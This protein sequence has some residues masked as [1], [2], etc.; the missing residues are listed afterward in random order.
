MMINYDFILRQKFCEINNFHYVRQNLLFE[1]K[2]DKVLHNLQNHSHKL[3]FGFVSII[4]KLFKTL[5][6]VLL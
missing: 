1:K 5:H 6:K 4:L 3:G 2:N